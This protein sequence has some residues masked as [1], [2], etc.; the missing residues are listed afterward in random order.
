M[1][2]TRDFAHIW[3]TLWIWFACGVGIATSITTWWAW[4]LP[5]NSTLNQSKLLVMNPSHQLSLFSTHIAGCQNVDSWVQPFCPIS[6]GARFISILW[7]YHTFILACHASLWTYDEKNVRTKMPLLLG[8]CTKMQHT[9]GPAH[10]GHIGWIC[11]NQI[12]SFCRVAGVFPLPV[13]ATTW[14][15][16]ESSQSSLVL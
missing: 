5:P 7:A 16:S 2:Y 9:K 12:L 10:R 15:S 13:V 8:G 14:E 1:K 3:K 4:C 6:N 11:Q